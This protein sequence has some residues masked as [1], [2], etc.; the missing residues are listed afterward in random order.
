[1]LIMLALYAASLAKILMDSFLIIGSFD[2]LGFELPFTPAL[3]GFISTF[4]DSLY[5]LMEDWGKLFSWIGFKVDLTWI[6]A[7]AIW[8]VNAMTSFANWATSLVGAAKVT[9]DGSQAPSYLVSNML[10]VVWIVMLIE[11]GIWFRLS[12]TEKSN[13][14]DQANAVVSKMV[15]ARNYNRAFISRAF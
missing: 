10:L 14:D 6:A 12:I 11:S 9:C 1:M 4:A 2:N 5:S 15:M 8:S 13:S 7:A 3:P